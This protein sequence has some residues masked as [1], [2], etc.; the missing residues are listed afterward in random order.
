[1]KQHTID[2]PFRVQNWRGKQRA[3]SNRCSEQEKKPNQE[4]ARGRV[5]LGRQEISWNY[6]LRGRRRKSVE[7]RGEGINGRW[8]RAWSINKKEN[9]KGERIEW[10]SLGGGLKE[11]MSLSSIKGSQQSRECA[12]FGVN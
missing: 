3:S 12:V 5:K 10:D 8:D 1:M 11:K 9:L 4:G 7:K 6:D 2:A